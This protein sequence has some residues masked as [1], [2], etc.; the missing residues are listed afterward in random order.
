ML[1]ISKH[2]INRDEILRDQSAY[3]EVMS[4]NASQTIVR[5]LSALFVIGLLSLFLPWTQNI[6]ARGKLTT[7]NPED[8]EQTIHS[9]ISGRIEKWYIREG[10]FVNFGDTIVHIS[11]IKSE[12]LD[13][14]LVEKTR[15]QS[16]A[17]RSSVDAYQQ[18]VAALDQRITALKKNQKLK[19]E[20]A[21]NYIEQAQ[22]KVVSDS[23][24]FATAEINLDIAERQFARQQ[25]L[26]DQGLKSLT[27]LE[28]RKQKKQESIN[29]HTSARN[30]WMASKN[31]LLN[32][33]I[34]RNNLVAE[35]QEKI[36]K[37][38]SE[39]M[40]A[41]SASYEAE[42]EY[43]KIS[44]LAE[45]YRRRSGFYYITAPQDGYVTKALIAGIG[46]TIKEGE[47]IFT[48]VPSDYDMAVE[49][50]VRPID[51]PLIKEGNKVRLQFDGWPALVFRGWPGM[52][53]GTFGGQVVAFD[54]AAQPD[55]TFRILVSPDKSE[56]DWPSL[57]R[58]GSGVYGIAL[59]NNVPV[60]YE[61][62][63]QLNGFP[64]DFYV[65]SDAKNTPESKSKSK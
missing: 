49:L 35:F 27:E 1:N 48:F 4:T 3:K 56:A 24:D 53:F 57:L 5:L 15:N 60:W 33:K 25:T 37:A 41:L 31:A 10:Q 30:K 61:L 7:L 43:N 55:G 59:L 19:V 14:E 65:S 44:I 58:L 20:V 21:D 62:W 50:H 39:R 12:Y 2:P 34:E 9:L 23:L 38:M 8:R 26:Y 11:E 18:K 6:R 29:K 16:A 32:A 54:K 40:S 36:S 63:R 51:L 52:T 17:K 22:L 47:E 28:T 64:P 46:E 13:P 42:G 45:S